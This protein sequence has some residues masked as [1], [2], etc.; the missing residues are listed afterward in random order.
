MKTTIYLLLVGLS[1]ISCAKE[2]AN[3]EKVEVNTGD[4]SS[5]FQEA[6]GTLLSENVPSYNEIAPNSSLKSNKITLPELQTNTLNNCVIPNRINQLLGGTSIKLYKF[7]KNNSASANAF[8][9][10]GEI[11]K[12]QMLFVQDYLRYDYINCGNQKKKVG[13]GLRCYI[14]VSDF[15]G[16]VGY[17]NLPGVAAN[18]ELNNAQCSYELKSLGFAIDGSVLAEGLNPEGEYNVENFGKLAATFNNV[19]KLLNGSN[20]MDIRPVELPND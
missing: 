20:P 4:V 7:D 19:L 2:S 12:K 13:I 17:N 6:E 15:K 16:K 18:V 1:L 9:F 3:A 14:F 8:G 11:G 10:T 5:V